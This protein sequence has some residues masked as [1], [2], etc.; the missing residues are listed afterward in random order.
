MLGGKLTFSATGERLAGLLGTP[1]YV[2]KTTVPQAV[3]FQRVLAL[4]EPVAHAE[5]VIDQVY[6]GPRLWLVSS[7]PWPLRAGRCRGG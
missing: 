7:W 4:A 3:V 1:L 6:N 5:C 2:C